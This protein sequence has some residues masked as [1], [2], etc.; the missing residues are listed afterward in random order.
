MFQR[1]TKQKVVTD[2]ATLSKGASSGVKPRAALKQVLFSQGGSDKTSE[3]LWCVSL[4]K[5]QRN[6]Y[7]LAVTMSADSNIQIRADLLVLLHW[8]SY[9]SCSH[10][11]EYLLMSINVMMH[12]MITYCIITLV[13]LFCLSDFFFSSCSGAKSTGCVEAGFG[14]FCCARKSEMEV[15]GGKSRSHAGEQ[16]DRFSE[17]SFSKGQYFVVSC[18]SQIQHKT[19]KSTLINPLILFFFKRDDKS[20]YFTFNYSV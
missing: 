11:F 18:L 14:G 10:K 9:F 15:E 5:L 16:L 20:C 6:R 19:Q 8:R 12:S 3:V 17:V 7:G 4:I 2:F 13:F 1:R